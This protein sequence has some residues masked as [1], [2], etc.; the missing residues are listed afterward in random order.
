MATLTNNMAIQS[1]EVAQRLMVLAS[2]VI[3][4]DNSA[5]NRVESSF[6]EG[7]FKEAFIRDIYF[8]ALNAQTIHVLTEDESVSVHL[9]RNNTTVSNWVTM[10]EPAYTS[11]DND[12]KD[13]WFCTIVNPF[14]NTKVYPGDILVF[15]APPADDGGTPVGDYA[16]SL[17]VLVRKY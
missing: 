7:E 16:I 13:R 17:T 10:S 15:V 9:L 6:P 4:A 1:H 2:G 8:T 14:Q 12:T 3:V 11:G 5:W